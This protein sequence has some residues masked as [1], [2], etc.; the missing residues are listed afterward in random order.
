M[1]SLW[2]VDSGRLTRSGMYFGAPSTG[3]RL[4][5]Y[6]GTKWGV[7]LYMLQRTRTA[8][9][10]NFPQF[11]FLARVDESVSPCSMFAVYSV[12]RFSRPLVSMTCNRTIRVLSPCKAPAIRS[13]A[14]LFGC[15]RFVYRQGLQAMKVGLHVETLL[16]K[17]QHEISRTLLTA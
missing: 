1:A 12:Y 13:L 15:S 3:Q 5:A 2:G 8:E 9:D 6:T 11:E 4:S 16:R 7:A 10:G 14:G 17:V